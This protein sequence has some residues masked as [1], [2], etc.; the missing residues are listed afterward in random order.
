[1]IVEILRTVV[2]HFLVCLYVVMTLVSHPPLCS[3]KLS[4]HAGY[5]R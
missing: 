4:K 1:M 2:E 5:K 3:K